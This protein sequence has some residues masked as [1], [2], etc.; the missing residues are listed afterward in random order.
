[1]SQPRK[2][3]KYNEVLSNTQLMQRREEAK[4]IL[5][6]KCMDIVSWNEQLHCME[7]SKWIQ[8]M[9]DQWFCWRCYNQM[10]SKGCDSYVAC[11]TKEGHTSIEDWNYCDKHEKPVRWHTKH[12]MGCKTCRE[13]VSKIK[14]PCKSKKEFQTRQIQLAEQYPSVHTSPVGFPSTTIESEVVSIE[15]CSLCGDL[16]D[17]GFLSSEDMM[18]LCEYC[19]QKRNGVF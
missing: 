16:L 17:Q 13:P 1:V 6:D 4:R 11:R 10:F 18:I 15:Q 14:E 9:D 12:G 8:K 19:Y 3:S 7:C 2:R 5:L